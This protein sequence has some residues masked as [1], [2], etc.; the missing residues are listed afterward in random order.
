[1]V[2]DYDQCENRDVETFLNAMAAWLNDC[3]GYYRNTGQTVNIDEP[4]WQLVADAL[5]AATVYD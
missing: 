5:S 3:G 2:A 4:N 1:M